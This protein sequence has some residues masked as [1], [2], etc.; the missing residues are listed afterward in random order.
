MSKYY[1]RVDANIKTMEIRWG[2]VDLIR[3][4]ITESIIDE[5]EDEV[6]V[7]FFLVLR[8]EQH[9]YEALRVDDYE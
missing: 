4:M 8:I 9:T 3:P 1:A 5:I 6:E 2:L 7:D